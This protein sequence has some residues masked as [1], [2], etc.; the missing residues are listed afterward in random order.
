M[1]EPDIMGLWAVKAQWS[2]NSQ[3]SGSTSSIRSFTVTDKQAS[4]ISCSVSSNILYAGN[5]IQI[6]GTVTPG[7]ANVPVSI[8][9]IGPNSEEEEYTVTTNGMGRYSLDFSSSSLGLWSVISSW[10]GDTEYLGAMSNEVTFSVD[11]SQPTITL[12]SSKSEII[13]GNEITL[14]GV[15]NPTIV[16]ADISLKI[17]NPED[18]TVYRELVTSSIGRYTETITPM[19]I[20]QWQVV[21]SWIGN[22][23]YYSVESDEVVFSV[24]ETPPQGSLILTISDES[25]TP[26][27]GASISCTSHPDYQEPLSGTSD[28]EGVIRFSNIVVG[29]YNLLLMKNEYQDYVVQATVMDNE[30][31]SLNIQMKKERGILKII[32]KD[33]RAQLLEGAG[34]TSTSQPSGQTTLNAQTDQTGSVSFEDIKFGSYTIFSSKEG[35]EST[36]TTLNIQTTE[37]I[38]ATLI[39]E[40]EPEPEPETESEKGGGIPGFPLESIIISM[41]LTTLVLW[42]I[43]RQQ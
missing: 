33:N 15:L 26:I 5:E 34:V 11:L 6:S 21:A 13:Q 10:S 4:T 8:L 27:N 24:I 28:S 35:Y 2:G 30:L 20:G 31:S 42:L 29:T 9:L 18:S 39:L 36:Q 19:D 38:E 23:L 7:R 1:Y 41:V 25:G 37:V 32:I 22:E 12:T 14:S 16:G 40:L 17:I 3:Y 43:Q